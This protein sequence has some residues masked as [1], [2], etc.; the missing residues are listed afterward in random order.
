MRD[1]VG[2]SR[3]IPG[4]SIK[5]FQLFRAPLSR[6]EFNLRK[7]PL[8]DAAGRF[9]RDGFSH[10]FWLRSNAVCARL[11]NR[12]DQCR[13][14]WRH[15]KLVAIS[16][17][18]MGPGPTFPACGGLP[19]PLSAARSLHKSSHSVGA[20]VPWLAMPTDEEK[21]PM[22]IRVCRA[23]LSDLQSTSGFE[24]RSGQLRELTARSS[25]SLRSHANRKGITA[26]DD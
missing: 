19:G 11:E 26:A 17:A 23:N 16:A 5:S 18:A 14:T 22:T 3:G 24:F 9:W 4:L 1:L 10:E 15:R 6:C 13:P 20:G 25:S 7:A 12:R 21:F 2:E 8:S